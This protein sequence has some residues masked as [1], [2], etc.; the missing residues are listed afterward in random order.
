MEDTQIDETLYAL[1][2]PKDFSFPFQPYPIQVD[3]MK[4]VFNAIEQKKIAI[5][6][7]PTGTGKSLSLIC[8]TMSWIAANRE[9]VQNAVMTD[10]QTRLAESMPDEPA[11]VIR[12]EVESMSIIHKEA[13]DDVLTAIRRET[14]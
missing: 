12:K 9:R 10:L 3:L 6:E 1:T 13:M 14:T 2:I 5:V 11:W 4:H 8:A 7:S